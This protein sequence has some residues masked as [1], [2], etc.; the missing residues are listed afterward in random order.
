MVISL[1]PPGLRDVEQLRREDGGGETTVGAAA[2]ERRFSPCLCLRAREGLRSSL[3]DDLYGPFC[4][5]WKAQSAELWQAFIFDVEATFGGGAWHADPGRRA[6]SSSV[7]FLADKRRQLR[8]QAA[9]FRSKGRA[10]FRM[11]KF[12]EAIASF[13]NC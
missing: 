6:V 5:R 12:L 13:F 1:V 9:S 4:C 7:C 2:T 8:H 10:R 3:M 11:C